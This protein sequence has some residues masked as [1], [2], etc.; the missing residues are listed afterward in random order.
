MACDVVASSR[1]ASGD[2]RH[3]LKTQPAKL[4]KVQFRLPEI[5]QAG[6][7]QV[8][9]GKVPPVRPTTPSVQSFLIVAG[10]RANDP[11]WHADGTKQR[12][13]MHPSRTHLI[14]PT[15]VFCGAAYVGG[16]PAN[17]MDGMGTPAVSYRIKTPRSRKYMCTPMPDGVS[18]S[19]ELPDNTEVA[20]ADAIRLL[21][22]RARHPEL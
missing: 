13:E 17:L 8:V 6:F 1:G 3:E 14:A 16:L 9:N 18:L 21:R 4:G 12:C 15:R 2:A 19:L 11:S 20:I 10:K 7:G 5:R 22:A